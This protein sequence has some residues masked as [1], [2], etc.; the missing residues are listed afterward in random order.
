MKMATKMITRIALSA[1][2]AIAMMFGMGAMQQ[3]AAVPT[4]LNLAQG[5]EPLIQQTFN[6]PCV[7]GD[8]SCTDGSLDHPHTVFPMGGGSQTY[9]EVSPVY[10]IADVRDAV[11]DFFRI[12]IDVN[13]T[14][15]NSETL[16]LFEILIDGAVEFVYNGP[17]S[18]A[19]PPANGT[20][21]SDWILSNVDISGWD[22]TSTIQFHVIISGAVDGREQIFLI[23]SDPHLA[24]EPATMA[25]FGT[26]LLGLAGLRRRRRKRA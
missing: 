20:G 24:P 25:L 2:F 7:I 5:T 9:D 8:E 13:T 6:N 1:G 15:A 18:I 14:Q 4:V 23:N 19:P 3:A 11:G 21:F 17:T 12:G 10:T 22:G 26:G 16:E